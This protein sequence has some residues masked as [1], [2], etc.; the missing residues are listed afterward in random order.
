MAG[1]NMSKE[2]LLKQMKTQTGNHIYENRVVVLSDV[3]DSSITQSLDVIKNT[4]N[5]HDIHLTIVGISS[6]FNS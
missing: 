5:E 3:C 2:L 6:D 4:A 1:F